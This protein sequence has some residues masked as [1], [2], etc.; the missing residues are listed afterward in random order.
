MRV[1]AVWRIAVAAVLGSVFASGAAWAGPGGICGF[2]TTT[3]PEPASLALLGTGV[4]GI[5]ILRR[6]LGRA[7]RQ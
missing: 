3:V 6:R 1:I 2:P 4:A 5:L 7:R